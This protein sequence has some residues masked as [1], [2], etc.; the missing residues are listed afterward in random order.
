MSKCIKLLSG[1]ELRPL[2][3]AKA[4]FSGLRE[5]SPIGSP[6]R[7]PERSDAVDIYQRYCRAT[8]AS[9]LAAVGVTVISERKLRPGGNYARIARSF[10]VVTAAGEAVA[11]NMEKALKAI[12]E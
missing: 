10:A 11:F 7:D 5:S 1:R 12:A 3:A 4:Y 9:P 6:L 8:G 2:T